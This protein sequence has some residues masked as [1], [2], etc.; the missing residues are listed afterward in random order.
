MVWC[1]SM[2]KDCWLVA[3]KELV[4]KVRDLLGKLTESQED[5]V[6]YLDVILGMRLGD[7]GRAAGGR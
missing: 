2:G 3:L 4:T 5:D 6:T 7:W 1:F